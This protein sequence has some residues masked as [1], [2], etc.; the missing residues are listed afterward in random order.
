MSTLSFGR[1]LRATATLLLATAGSVGAQGTQG[2]INVRVT[3]VAGGR[4]LDQ[5]QLVIVG[6]TLGGLTNAE[7]RFTFRAVSAGTITLRALR[8]GYGEEKRS[9]TVTAGQA[10][11]VTFA[12]REVALTLAPVVTTATGEIRRTEL[13]NAIAS[14]DVAKVTESSPVQNVNDLLN[15]RTAGVTVISGTQTGAG[16][17]I[18]IRGQNSLSLSN[19]PIFIID[20]VRMTNNVGSSNLFTGGSQPSRV[21]D[22]NPEDI[23]SMEIVKGPSAATL[24]GT[25]AA[26]GVVLITTK[27]GRA[28]N[29]RWTIYG[30]AGHIQDQNTYPTNYTIFG[31]R[32]SNGSALAINGCNLPLLSSGFCTIDSVA[33][34]NLFEDDDVTPLSNG[35]R[36]QYGLQLSGGT[37]VV[38]YFVSGEREDETGVLELP[39]FEYRRFESQELPLHDWTKR[40]NVLGKNSVR[41][42]LN[43]AVTPKL[44]LSASTGFINIAQRFSLE[45][46][47]T[48]GLGS[49]AFGGPGCKICS[50]ERVVGTGLLNTP[51]YGYRAWTPGYT[52]QEKVGQ[53]VNRFI[54]AFNANWRPTDWLQNRLTIGNDLTGRVDDNLLLRGEGPPITANYRLGFKQNSRAD[55]RNFTID[56]GSTASYTPRPWLSLKTTGGV[57]YV[58]YLFEL[59]SATGTQLAPG[60]QTAG[61]GAVPSASEASTLQKTLGV[62]V[63]QAAAIND[64]LFLT[65]AVRSDQNSA[66]GTNFQSV[67]YPKGSISWV[68]SDEAFFPEWGWMDQFRFRAAIGSSG[69]QPGPNDALRFYG[70]TTA[71]Y[72][73]VDTP[74]V[75]YS[76]IGNPDLKPERSTEF[77]TG[78]DAKFLNSRYSLELTYYAKKTQDAI[79]SA[80]QPPSLG[81]PTSQ[82]TNIGS[83]RNWG[84][85]ALVS[86]QLV[87]KRNFAWDVS[88]NASTNSNELVSLGGTP[89]QIGVTTR[90][91]EGYPLFGLWSRA[92]TGWS[93]KNGDKIL[94]YNSD[95]NLNEVFVADSFSFRGYSQPRHLVTWTNGLDFFNRRLRFQ[96]M[97]DFRGG[98]VW[99]NNTERIRC[100]SR[101]NCNG[102]QNPNASFEEQAMVVATRNHPSASLDGF[103][104][105]G[106]FVRFREATIQYT[107]SPE[108]A[109]RLFKSR[110]V[111][112]VL[113][114]RNVARWTDYR[115]VDPE[116]D[117]NLTT[118]TDNA[119]GDFQTIGLP[120]YYI[121]RVN[122]NR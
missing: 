116:S 114:G 30:E 39:K 55:I 13:G 67:Y 43:A 8:V 31:R 103:L 59:G 96:T 62:F 119:G 95:P 102:L 115:G 68:M 64:R 85:E 33:K 24:Y 93:D 89:P 105:P 72:R 90:A 19:D 54:G 26:N 52:W 107:L 7:G 98:H 35:Y 6:T 91:V 50:P 108:L 121:L 12:L 51:L 3:E 38:R 17:R 77:E 71:N 53:R 25:D 21:G 76:A 75:T 122:I 36:S 81:G 97:L 40:P 110:G 99:Y 34:Y 120:S 111:S 101:Q 29:A 47:A 63:E 41:A 48:A 20:G 104:Q 44:D 86:G 37:D 49:H 118:G 45:S 78:F 14:I 117:F 61:G 82:R 32:V 80:I 100:V 42:N 65:A 4:P 66:F 16:A 69:V 112:F 113:S 46:N 15:S 84:W 10:A 70:A 11:E 79:I 18:R 58:N 92:I 106:E 27:R 5:V 2:S 87:D 57:Q 109:S 88:L 1:I 9:V 56:L 83:V 73:G 28:G 60:S 74:A 94:T 23:E 22:L